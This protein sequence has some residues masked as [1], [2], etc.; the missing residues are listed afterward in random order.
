MNTNLRAYFRSNLGGTRPEAIAGLL[1]GFR[2]RGRRLVLKRLRPPRPLLSM[3]VLPAIWPA[4][5]GRAPEL[6]AQGNGRC[7][8]PISGAEILL[9]VSK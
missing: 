5:L 7:P 3:P 8:E 1:D 6:G 2:G 4:M 9:R